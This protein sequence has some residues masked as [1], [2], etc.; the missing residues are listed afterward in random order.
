VWSVRLSCKQLR[1][2]TVPVVN[3]YLAA[4]VCMPSG[5]VE[6]APAASLGSAAALTLHIATVVQEVGSA[7]E[8]LGILLPCELCAGAAGEG[9]RHNLN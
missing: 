8:E 9:R 6:V 5:G 4:A 3:D 1:I 7:C 2:L